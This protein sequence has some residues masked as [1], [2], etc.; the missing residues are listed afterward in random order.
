MSVITFL[1]VSKKIASNTVI[2]SISF[3]LE[4]GSITTLVGP[5]G[6]GK[7]TIARLMLGIDEPSSGQ[8]IC[9]IKKRAY[10]PQRIAL[11]DNLPLNA[12]TLINVLNSGAGS[13]KIDISSF[14]DIKE[15]GGKV[16]SALSGGQLQKVFITAAMLSEP[17]LLVLD[18]PTQGLD[19]QAQSDLYSMIENISTTFGITIFMISH[20][21]HTVMN[22][23]DKV[24]C[25]NHHICCSGK[26]DKKRGATLSHIGRYT[27]HHDHTH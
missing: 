21:L 7:T 2:D 12:Q 16:L 11:D 22:K 5:N 1:D 4:R 17:E 27:H 8:I 23:S 6:A 13:S 26:P 15:F 9:N 19:I 14:I 10:V 18:E 25:L 24:L 20:D 3:E